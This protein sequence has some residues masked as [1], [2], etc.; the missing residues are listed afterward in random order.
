MTLAEF[1]DAYPDTAEVP[2]EMVQAALDAST[3]RVNED[4]WGDL[5][6]AGHGAYAYYRLSLTTWGK[7]AEL[8]SGALLEGFRELEGSLVLV[9]GE[10]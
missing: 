7:T 6:D 2:D 3:V 5:F 9:M 1:R 4:V 8:D 10:L